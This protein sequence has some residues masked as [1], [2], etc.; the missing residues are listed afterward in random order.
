VT[1]VVTFVSQKRVVASKKRKLKLGA[2]S[3]SAAADKPVTLKAKLS[4]K[5]FKTLKR[6]KK[7]NVAAGVDAHCKDG[8]ANKKNVTFTLKAPKAKRK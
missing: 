3:F 7:V 1:G 4:K 2:K 5:G 6:L 8:N